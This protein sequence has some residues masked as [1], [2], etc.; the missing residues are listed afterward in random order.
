MH[1][2]SHFQL[3]QMIGATPLL[4]LVPHLYK[5]NGMWIKWMNEWTPIICPSDMHKESFSSMMCWKSH[6][7][8]HAEK[9]Q[10]WKRKCLF[11]VLYYARKHSCGKLF[12][13]YVYPA[14]IYSCNNTNYN[15]FIHINIH[16]VHRHQIQLQTLSVIKTFLSFAAH[17]VFHSLSSSGG[18]NSNVQKTS[19]IDVKSFHQ[20]IRT[21]RKLSVLSIPSNQVWLTTCNTNNKNIIQMY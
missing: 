4:W 14:C 1:L 20:Y 6:C 8:Q 13:I 9:I 15:K 5:I 2:T 16:C 12:L 10:F 17:A 21:E 19:C 18:S 11:S 7:Q 3:V